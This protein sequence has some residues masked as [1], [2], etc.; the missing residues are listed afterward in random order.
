MRASATRNQTDL[1]ENQGLTSINHVDELVFSTTADMDAL[2][3]SWRNLEHRAVGHVF[4]TWSWVSNWH[5]HV[6]TARNISPLIITATSRDGV[7]RALLP[8]GVQTRAGFRTLV[9][10]G[11]EHADYKGPLLDTDLAAQLT[12]ETTRKLFGAAFRMVPGIDAVRLEDMPMDLDG[13]PHPMLAYPHQL[14]PSASHALTLEGGFDDLYDARRGSSSRKKLRQKQRR[15]EKAIGP[16][17][18][19]IS[20]SPHT[21][22]KAIATLIR[23]KRTRLKEIGAADMF[24]APEVRAFYRS[25]AEQHPEICQL[26]TFEA[27]GT[28]LAAN[29]GLVWGDRYYYVLSTITDGEYRAHS[30]GQLH[31]NNLIAW[32]IARGLSTFDFTKGDEPYKDDWCDITTDLFDVYLGLTIKGRVAAFTHAKTRKARR[33]IKQSPVLWP[34]A[35]KLRK[36]AK[37]H[38]LHT[39]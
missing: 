37:E 7:L 22:S 30:P 19:S 35:K 27:D 36:L 24:A 20:Y 10:L 15:L 9:W 26:S 23:Q 2:R 29:W 18:M 13:A 12:P 38:L 28:I 8:M 16:T 17:G 5:R 25:L 4:Q 11:A 6:G 1:L 32:S 34:W 21:R 39:P 31:L 14:G 33:Y 3:Q